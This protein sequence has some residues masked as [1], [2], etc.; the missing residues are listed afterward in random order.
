MNHSKIKNLLLITIVAFS[1]I[2][3]KDEAPKDYVTLQGK[4][5]NH[6][7]G[8]LTILG[9]QF[10]KDIKIAEDGTFQDTLKVKD[11]FHGLTD[12]MQQTFLYLKNGYDLTINFDGDTFPV[13]IEF[14][15]NGANTNQYLTQKIDLIEKEGLNDL[16]TIF[17]L[18]KAAFD[19]KMKGVGMK[20]DELLK[21]AKDLDPEVQKMEIEANVKML[22]YFNSN[23]ESEHNKLMAFAP[24]MPSPKFNYP[25]V[26]GKK[27]S[28]D[29]LKG[30]V[31]YIDV[32]A[33]WCAPCKYEI[34]YLKELNKEYANA[35]LAIVSLSIDEVEN[36]EKWLQM[37]KDEELKGIQLWADD[38][39]NS[40]FLASYGVQAIPRFILIDREGKIVDANAPRPS[41]PKLKAM[42]KSLNL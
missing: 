26:N 19:E 30:K 34:P 25:D 40:E 1:V 15:G 33:T 6:K 8:I 9:N 39:Q 28:L 35:D 24:G 17:S 22:E 41:D 4:I 21:S 38:A 2:A 10:K 11:G 29:D 23:Y 18:D 27:I 31:V 7:G 36:K 20:A 12:G 42:L 14:D 3:C 13:A 37:V 5:I 16:K 32:W